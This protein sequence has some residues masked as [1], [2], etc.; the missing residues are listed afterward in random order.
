MITPT[1]V[2]Y[3]AE[4]RPP[5]QVPHPPPRSYKLMNAHYAADALRLGGFLNRTTGVVGEW[6][7]SGSLPWRA[8]LSPR[9][10]LCCP[11]SRFMPSLFVTASP[12]YRTRLHSR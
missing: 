7:R 5:L 4:W 11:R 1:L 3:A 6:P 8:Y 9:S 10:S 2:E 12:R